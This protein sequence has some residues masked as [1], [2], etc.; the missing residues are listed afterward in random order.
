[1]VIVSAGVG[2]AFGAW[3]QDKCRGPEGQHQNKL[4]SVLLKII[5]F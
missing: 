5:L 1:M 3:T 4:E 2:T